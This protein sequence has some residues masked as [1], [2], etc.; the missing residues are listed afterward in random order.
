MP[1]PP[2]DVQTSARSSCLSNPCKEQAR[3]TDGGSDRHIP[4]PPSRHRRVVE[5]TLL[6]IARL[7]ENMTI[8]DQALPC[9][10]IMGTSSNAIGA[11]IATGEKK[12]A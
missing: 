7:A 9:N 1:S 11:S 10:G 6:C 5:E 2:Q 8:H 3:S 4:V 12:E